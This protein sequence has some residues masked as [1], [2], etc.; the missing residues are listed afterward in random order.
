VLQDT[1]GTGHADQRIT[2]LSGLGEHREQ[3]AVHGVVFGK[4]GLLYMTLGEFNCYHIKTRDGTE[5][6]GNSGALLRCKPDGSNLEV[7]CRGLGNLVEVAF[8]DCGEIIGGANWYQKP[9]DGIRDSLA[10]LVEGGLYH[11]KL[12]DQDAPPFVG[13]PLPPLSAFPAIAFSGLTVYRGTGASAVWRGNVFAAEFNTRKVSRHVLVREGS[14]FKLESNYLITNGDDDFH[15][16]DV[17][18][19]ADG[20]LLVV[21]TGSWYV[22]RCPTSPSH[23]NRSRGGIWRIRDANAVPISDP[24]GLQID[25]QTDPERLVSLLGDGRPAVRDHAQLKLSLQGKAAVPILAG[26]LDKSP[27]CTA[28]QHA[29][30]GLAAIAEDDALPP[31]RRSL[32]DPEPEVVATAA[33]ALGLRRDRKAA[34][35]L[36]ELLRHREA[37]VRLAAAEALAH[38]GD[39]AAL[40]ALWQALSENPDPLLEH[41]LVHAAHWLADTSSLQLALQY[42]HPRVQHAALILLEQPSRPPQQLKPEIVLNAIQSPDPGL[43]RAAIGVF[44]KHPEWAEQAGTLIHEWLA[45]PDLSE[46]E[47]R[48]LRGLILAFQRQAVIQ[49]FVATALR[50]SDSEVSAERVCYL[51]DIVAESSLAELPNRWEQALAENLENSNAAVRLH[52]VKTVAV[53]QLS[54]FDERLLRLAE[55]SKEVLEIRIESLRGVL[56][57][58]RDL[59]A[60]TFE[61]LLQQLGEEANPLARLAASEILGSARVTEPQLVKVLAKVR[62]DTLISPAV[63]L[64]AVPKSLG[65]SA[66]H[67]LLDYLTEAAS[68]GWRPTDPELVRVSGSLPESARPRVEELRARAHQARDREGARLAGYEP[69]LQG[70]DAQRGRGIFFGKKVACATCHRIGGQGGEVGPDLTKIGAI[71]AGKD[72]LE[73]ILAPS[74]T[75]A[76]E[77]E[78]YRVI[79][80]NER[81]ATG[82]IARQSPVELIL[83]DTSGAELRFR[84]DQ[85]Q[86]LTRMKTSLMPEGQERALTE[87]EF[88]DLLAYLQSL[89]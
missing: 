77:Y 8:T 26:V 1:K 28:K 17:L 62:G 44:Q 15:P 52:A 65:E 22:G 74:A 39:R 49:N 84:K 11:P 82:T 72:I 33:R 61:F 70:G 68:N 30:W 20:S 31:L 63:L 59:S 56:S 12:Q 69:L 13:Q 7:V 80:R 3:T 40:P 29:V 85:I 47:Y 76:Q 53:L 14:T 89:R 79:A 2:L 60:T 32:S 35:A 27:G 25:W 4:D 10:H 75:V 64:R 18:E 50:N 42:P 81:T 46:E 9:K 48:G 43:R 16:T 67:S 6:K 88:R 23:R 51:L 41:A 45:K 37:H 19:S 54:Q 34:G 21:D 24:W 57:R 36:T 86:E 73:A 78:T 83:R 38:S 55:N 71:R 66:A 5:I 58:Q 87:E